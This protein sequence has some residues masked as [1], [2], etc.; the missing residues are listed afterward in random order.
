LIIVTSAKQGQ[1]LEKT[2]TQSPSD[3]VNS[4][5]LILKDQK[6]ADFSITY[7]K[8]NKEGDCFIEIAAEKLPRLLVENQTGANVQAKGESQ[9]QTRSL[10]SLGE[11]LNTESLQSRIGNLSTFLDTV[12]KFSVKD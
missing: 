7:S 9:S 10:I 3:A 12:I 11:W 6:A 2:L 5:Y 4:K 8:K 1:N